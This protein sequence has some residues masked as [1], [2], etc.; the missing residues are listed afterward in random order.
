MSIF[1]MPP[2]KEELIRRLKSRGTDSEE[3]IQKRMER[4]DYEM[5]QACHFDHVV[6]NDD[7]EEAKAKV[8]ALVKDFINQQ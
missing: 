1:I 5:A 2:S 6:V 4:V 7:L 8:L 3:V